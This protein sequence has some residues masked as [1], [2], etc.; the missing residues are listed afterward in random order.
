MISFLMRSDLGNIKFERL[1]LSEVD[2]GMGHF[3]LR[4]I[5]FEFRIPHPFR[6]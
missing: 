2:F 5:A 6:P 1:F 4:Q 3:L